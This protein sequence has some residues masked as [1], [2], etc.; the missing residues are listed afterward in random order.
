MRVNPAIVPK[1]GTLTPGSTW[2]FECVPLMV[3]SLKVASVPLGLR[4]EWFSFFTPHG[5]CG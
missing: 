3:F 4:F 5:K 2:G 1:V